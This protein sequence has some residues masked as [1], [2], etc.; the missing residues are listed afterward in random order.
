M[1]V[2]AGCRRT[3]HETEL[4]RVS[5]VP[6]ECG[7]G[8]DGVGSSGEG[9]RV[10]R[11]EWRWAGMDSQVRRAVGWG[12]RCPACVAARQE[13]LGG[14]TASLVCARAG[15]CGRRVGL[16]LVELRF[17]G[18]EPQNPVPGATGGWMLSYDTC[19]VP[20]VSYGCMQRVM[21][22]G[23]GVGLRCWWWWMRAKGVAFITPTRCLIGGWGLREQ[24][25][26]LTT[27]HPPILL[28]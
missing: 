17:G 3:R 12:G 9:T 1:R 14:P 5:E 25:R 7:P 2:G 27:A 6:V 13:E 16:R 4:L 11:V 23:M 20:Y 28:V 24:Q 10:V 26:M 18:L 8:G 15:G 22:G 19:R 21:V